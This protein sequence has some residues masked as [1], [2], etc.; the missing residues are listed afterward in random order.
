[1]YN[2]CTTL[3]KIVI[4]GVE[5]CLFKVKR[6]LQSFLVG[7]KHRILPRSIRKKCLQSY[8]ESGEGLSQGYF[9]ISVYNYG[10]QERKKKKESE[11]YVPSR[12]ALNRN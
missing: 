1:M 2:I 12:E 7:I 8:L 6:S 9:S 5:K 11:K 3:R 10:R 4:S